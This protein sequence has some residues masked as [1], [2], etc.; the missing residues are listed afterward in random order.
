MPSAAAPSTW[1][2][3][4]AN[5]SRS[6]PCSSQATPST[7]AHPT[8]MCKPS[9]TSSPPPHHFDH[10]RMYQKWSPRPLLFSLL[11]QKWS[12]RPPLL[13]LLNQKWLP[14]PFLIRFWNSIENGVDTKWLL[15]NCCADLQTCRL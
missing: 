6:P 1:A 13:S 5:T 8:S 9:P 3:T 2:N 10:K 15:L 7:V 11:N 14:K 4:L 12:P